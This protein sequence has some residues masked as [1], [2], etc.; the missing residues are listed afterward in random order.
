[1]TTSID[2][3][4]SGLNTTQLVAQ[5]MQV[6]ALP[7]TALKNKV[8]TEQSAVTAY[9][10]VNTKLAALKA[11]AADMNS[12]LTWGAVKASSSSDAVIATAA[13][14][15]TPGETTF[16]VTK[17]ARAQLSTLAAAADGTVT[18]GGGLD[19]SIGGAAAVHI[20]VGTDTLAGAASAINAAGLGV[21]ASVV[22]TD[23]GPL[24]Q[25]ASTKIGAANAFTVAG[26]ASTASTVVAASDAQIT[27]G[28][29]AHGG[30]TAT[31]TT[32]SFTGVIAGVTFT[33]THV[34][35]GVTVSVT[36]DA[37]AIADRMKTMVDAANASLTELDKQTAYDATKKT[38]APLTGNFAVRDLGQNILSS[39]SGGLVG[40]GSYKA[41]GVGLSSTGQLTFDRDAFLTAYQA[42]PAKT[43]A[44]LSTGL[45]KSLQVV[46]AGATDTT[47]GTI[48]LAVRSRTDSIRTL[49]T[50][51]G[52]W[53]IRLTARQAT[54]QRQYAN[55]EVTLGKL[56][57]QS[58]WLS[59]QISSLPTNG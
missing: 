38:A 25:L 30:Y 34:Q 15:A 55:L 5:L 1:M 10:S 26:A 35:A 44:T 2:G 57:S 46:A 41:I 6:E 7:Q 27:V 33:A 43:Q 16:D 19:I 36:P 58:S 22:T 52:D 59:G 51:I 4:I 13:P 39:V 24:L 9:Q 54:L 17:L 23:Q 12:T 50:D 8:T 28:D 49:T 20:A 14:G 37:G 31:S 18:T 56:K 29:P 11:A 47:N 3:L 40:T 42:D 32:N 53:D 45:A 21:R 48:T